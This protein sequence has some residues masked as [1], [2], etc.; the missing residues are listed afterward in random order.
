M[1]VCGGGGGG[2]LVALFP[3]I[4]SLGV[5]KGR[6]GGGGGGGSSKAQYSESFAHKLTVNLFFYNNNVTVVC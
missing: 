3:H 2:L 5:G 4:V 1:C 6:G